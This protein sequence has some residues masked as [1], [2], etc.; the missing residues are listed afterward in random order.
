[1]KFENEVLTWPLRAYGDIIRGDETT[2]EDQVG[3]GITPDVTCRLVAC[4]NA[5]AGISTIDLELGNYKIHGSASPVGGEQMDFER[6]S[7]EPCGAGNFPKEVLTPT[8][9]ID[10]PMCIA[11]TV[12]KKTL[13][14]MDNVDYYKTKDLSKTEAMAFA[15]KLMA[16]AA[17]MDG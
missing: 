17:A 7:G 9:M 4:W 2:S 12:D 16:L 10:V 5:C 13:L 3:T 14:L 8:E 1:M 15:E 11:L 6:Y